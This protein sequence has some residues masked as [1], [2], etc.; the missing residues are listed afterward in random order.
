MSSGK[1][2][3][4]CSLKTNKNCADREIDTSKT[5]LGHPAYFATQSLTDGCCLNQKKTRAQFAAVISNPNERHLKLTQ[6]NAQI[7][8]RERPRIAHR[9]PQTIAFRWHHNIP[10]QSTNSAELILE[11]FNVVWFILEHTERAFI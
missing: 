9:E 2:T 5:L 10:T 11:V 3:G 6:N 7:D 1:C 4:E 8:Q